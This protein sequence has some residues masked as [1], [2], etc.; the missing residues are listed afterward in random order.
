MQH[1]RIRKRARARTHARTHTRTH[2]HTHTHWKGLHQWEKILSRVSERTA[3][4]GVEEEYFTRQQGSRLNGRQW[5]L[6]NFQSSMEDNFIGSNM[7]YHHQC[8]HLHAGSS[9]RLSGA[10]F[11]SPSDD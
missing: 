2:T 11:I 9:P 10:E 6:L 1:E 7:T 5:P 3:V 8:L 4:S